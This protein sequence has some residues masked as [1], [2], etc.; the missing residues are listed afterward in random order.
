MTFVDEI[1]NVV[2][3]C[4]VVWFPLRQTVVCFYDRC[5]AAIKEY[6]ISLLMTAAGASVR[7]MLAV[8][9]IR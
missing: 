6:H 1:S 3:P 8:G 2:R 7:A 9:L 5:S 4:F